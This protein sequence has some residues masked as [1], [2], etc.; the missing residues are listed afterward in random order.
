LL[1]CFSPAFAIA[2]F[3]KRQSVRNIAAK[4]SANIQNKRSKIKSFG[5][6]VFNSY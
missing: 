6:F 2:Y 4:K 5:G 3:Y 1:L